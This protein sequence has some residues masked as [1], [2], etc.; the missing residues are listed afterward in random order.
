MRFSVYRLVV[1]IGVAHRVHVVW[2]HGLVIMREFIWCLLT[3]HVVGCC[4]AIL[5]V[6]R[7]VLI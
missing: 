4:D 2:V 1:S 3:M 6:A 5:I 7:S